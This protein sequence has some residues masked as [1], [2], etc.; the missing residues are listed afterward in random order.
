[1]AASELTASLFHKRWSA[2]PIGYCD[3][4]FWTNLESFCAPFLTT[5]ASPYDHREFFYLCSPE[6]EINSAI[7]SIP[8]EVLEACSSTRHLLTMFSLWN[9]FALAGLLQVSIST[10]VEQLLL[11]V[12]KKWVEMCFVVCC[13]SCGYDITHCAMIRELNAGGPR[14]APKTYRCPIC[15]DSTPI[16][17]LSDVYVFFK[18]KNLPPAFNCEHYRLSWT[19]VAESQKLESIF[20]PSGA[21]FAVSLQL[22]EGR[23]LL[24]ASFIGALLE[25]EVEVGCE[26]L[27]QR[28]R[29]LMQTIDLKK[30]ILVRKKESNLMPQFDFRQKMSLPTLMKR[31]TVT[32]TGITPL[33][34]FSALGSES[35]VGRRDLL[36]ALR[37]HNARASFFSN[38]NGTGTG[39]GDHESNASKALGEETPTFVETPIQCLK[40]KHGKVKFILVNDTSSSGFVDLFVGFERCAEFSAEVYPTQL[41]VSE[42]MHYIPRGLRSKFIQHCVPKSPTTIPTEGIF[43]RHFFDLSLNYFKDPYVVSVIQEVHRYSLEDHHGLLLTVSNGGTSYDSSFFSIT[44]AIAS[45]MSFFQRVLLRL[46]DDVALSMRCSINNASMHLTTYQVQYNDADNMRSAYPDAQ[47]VGPAVYY[48]SHPSIIPPTLCAFEQELPRT[49]VKEKKYTHTVLNYDPFK[50]SKEEEEKLL[51]L[52]ASKEKST[53]VRFEIRNLLDFS[54]TGEFSR[55]SFSKSK[56]PRMSVV[57]ST[58]S[59]VFHEP[60]LGASFK[61]FI[62]DVH[63]VEDESIPRNIG[64]YIKLAPQDDVLPY[65]LIHLC[66]QLKG[67]TI[68][69][70]PHALVILVPL[71]TLQASVQL[72]TL[73]DSSCYQKMSS[74]PF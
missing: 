5:K 59:S 63:S 55:K 70:E 4:N 46:G 18:L 16:H 43:V 74:G 10:V 33:R 49:V 71:P 36:T 2:L 58:R 12:E 30:Y 38:T 32:S 54:G 51:L 50:L 19:K 22:P 39:F 23:Y 52:N 67:M 57:R 20:C 45:S 65:F 24:V 25:L 13:V 17:S 69:K 53:M 14:Y 35:M 31:T 28:E 27:P 48:S 26:D 29:T 37:S 47:F 3:R 34:N 9:P 7:E 21:K 64:K 1:M 41:T 62:D 56:T 15:T 68:V 61:E 6:V 60:L 72:P 66:E 42:F 11:G 40:L 44:A 8:S 73:L